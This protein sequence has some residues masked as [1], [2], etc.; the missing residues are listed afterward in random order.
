MDLKSN[1]E[2]R[3]KR[4]KEKKRGRFDTQKRG[5]YKVPIEA[6]TGVMESKLK[7]AGLQKKLYEQGTHSPLPIQSSGSHL[8]YAVTL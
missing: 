5:D 3:L 1:H 4:Q 6:E 2:Y 7:N 8:P